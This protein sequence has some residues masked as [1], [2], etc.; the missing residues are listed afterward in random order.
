M[1]TIEVSKILF[2]HGVVRQRISPEHG[3]SR[4]I[5]AEQIQDGKYLVCGGMGRHDF[6]EFSRPIDAAELYIDLLKKGMTI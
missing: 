6:K 1:K 4:T 2:M 3:L 5:S